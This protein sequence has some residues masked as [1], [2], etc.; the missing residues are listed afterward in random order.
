MIGDSTI[1]LIVRRAR[2]YRQRMDRT[3]QF[4]RK[5]LINEA[6]PRDTRFSGEKIRR[7][8]QLKMAFAAGSGA[9]VAGVTDSGRKA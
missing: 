7:N 9:S 8:L 2:L 3:G 6:L 5:G 4:L 1:W